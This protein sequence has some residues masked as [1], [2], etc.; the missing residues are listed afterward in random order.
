[1]DGALAAPWYLD[2]LSLTAGSLQAKPGKAPSEQLDRQER[3]QEEQ[4][5]GHG[6][7]KIQLFNGV[8][9]SQDPVCYRCDNYAA[10]KLN[11]R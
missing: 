9:D 7:A 4:D 10:R 11:L 5:R 1:M 8:H 3:F 6:Q 2:R